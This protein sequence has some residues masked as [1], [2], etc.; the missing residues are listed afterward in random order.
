MAKITKIWTDVVEI[1]FNKSNMP[2]INDILLKKDKTSSFM[3][4]K[5]VD[6]ETVYAMIIRTDGKIQI[7]D[8]IINTKSSF[9]VP[10]GKKD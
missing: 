4:K 6:D 1:N 9:M 3:V 10:V 5:I 7:N 2:K 8:E